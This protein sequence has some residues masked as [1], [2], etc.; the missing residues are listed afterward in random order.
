MPA[1]LTDNP[2]TSVEED[3]F[4]FALYAR[5]LAEAIS[6]TENLP[7]CLGIFGPWGSGKTSLMRMI[8]VLLAKRPSTKTL[9]FN[10]WKYDKKEDLWHALIQSILQAIDDATIDQDVKDKITNLALATTW[11]AIKKAVT[12]FSGGF[13]TD[14]DL[15]KLVSAFEKKD[16]LLYRH[17]NHFEQDF[18]EV[19]GTYVKGGRLVVFIDDL[20]R[21]LPENGITVL[22]SLKLFV[23]DA[24]CVF[25]LGMDDHVVEEGI[26]FRYQDKLK[27][28][29]RDYLDKM[30]QV[31]FYLPPVPFIRL[32]ETL[33]PEDRSGELSEEIWRVIEL[34]MSGNPRRTKRFLNSFT[35]LQR[36]LTVPVAAAGPSVKTYALSPRTQGIYLAKLLV[37]QIAFPEFYQHLQLAPAAWRTLEKIVAET[38]TGQQN[39][40]DHHPELRAFWQDQRLRQFL[41]GTTSSAA[42]QFP[43]PPADTIVT[44]MLQAVSLVTDTGHQRAQ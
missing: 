37:F 18:S 21:C 40:L 12:T 22:E 28:S 14:G 43:D 39:P 34:G 15:D 13:V 8:R 7:L 26:R 38:K 10:P 36:I 23:G 29:G 27:L 17:I 30:I 11:A 16:E 4:G 32:R 41:S 6:E 1:M 44:L 31:P 42:Q 20:D 19:V 35:L 3:A 9:W 25:V 2:I 5:I 33:V 24:R